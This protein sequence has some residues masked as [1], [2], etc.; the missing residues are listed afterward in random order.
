[1]HCQLTN[2]DHF[3]CLFQVNHERCPT[4]KKM[5]GDIMTHLAGSC[6]VINAG[7]ENPQ[8]QEFSRWHGL[9]SYE[10]CCV[11]QY[12]CV[13]L[14]GLEFNCDGVIHIDSTGY[15]NFH[16]QTYLE[17][18]ASPNWRLQ[19]SCSLKWM[20][21]WCTASGMQTALNQAPKI[22]CAQFY[23]IQKKNLLHNFWAKQW[24]RHTCIEAHAPKGGV[25]RSSL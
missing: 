23:L 24:A 14:I 3:T 8:P 12:T 20:C 22:I 21:F 5:L 7:C 25:I 15:F 6:S 10:D 2:S 17:K 19:C 18:C 1:M 9:C 11:K 4:P 16:G 13:P